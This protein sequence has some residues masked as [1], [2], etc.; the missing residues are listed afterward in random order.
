MRRVKT[1]HA[2]GFALVFTVTVIAACGGSS[3]GETGDAASMPDASLAPITTKTGDD[4]GTGFQT[5][6][7]GSTFV[8]TGTTPPDDTG[9]GATPT[10]AATGSA[11]TGTGTGAADTGTGTMTADSATGGG[12]CPSSCTADSECASACPTTPG[13]INCCDTV[14][15]ACFSSASSVC[16]DQMMSGGD[17]GSGGY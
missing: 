9:T 16:P 4:T 7:V 12:V 17:S 10:D 11:D 1:S 3:E 15:S 13:A 6:D 5:P 8:D 2:Y 14:T